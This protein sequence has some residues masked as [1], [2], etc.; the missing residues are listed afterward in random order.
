MLSQALGTNQHGIPAR[1]R[2]PIS[3]V[4]V[5]QEFSKE[6]IDELA[7]MQSSSTLDSEPLSAFHRRLLENARDSIVGLSNRPVL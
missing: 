4:T 5:V 1:R 3:S 2:K 6:S 7:D